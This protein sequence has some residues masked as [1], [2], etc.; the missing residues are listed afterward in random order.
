MF[1]RIV[2]YFLLFSFFFSLSHAC[3]PKSYIKHGLHNSYVHI[4]CVTCWKL[5]LYGPLLLLHIFH[6]RFILVNNT[7]CRTYF[8]LLR[9]DIFVGICSVAIVVTLIISTHSVTCCPYTS[10]AFCCC[11]CNPHTYLPYSSTFR[12]PHS[13]SKSPLNVEMRRTG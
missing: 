7:I 9:T 5:H 10:F 6:G 4:H 2:L 8:F 11:Y 13:I 12:Q 1:N 3:P